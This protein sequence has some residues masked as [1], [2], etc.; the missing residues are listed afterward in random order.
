M[1]TKPIIL[2]ILMLGTL[3]FAAA[4]WW[5]TPAEVQAR[6]NDNHNIRDKEEPLVEEKH[7]QVGDEHDAFHEHETGSDDHNEKE[8]AHAGEEEDAHA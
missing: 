2:T 7:D 3:A 6:T 8:A 4:T 1:K 5:P